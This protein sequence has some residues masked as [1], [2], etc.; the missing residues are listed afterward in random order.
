MDDERQFARAPFRLLAIGDCNTEGCAQLPREASLPELI[1][2]LLRERGRTVEVHNWGRTMSTTREGLARVRREP[3][4]A[5]VVLINFG[6]VDAWVTTI[7]R[8]YIP[9]YPD[10]FLRKWGRKL[11]KTLKRRLRQPWLKRFVP[12]GEVVPLDEY[13]DNVERMIASLRTAHPLA[14]IVLWGTVPVLHDQERNR[15]LI[16]YN[17]SLRDLAASHNA[18]YVDA[19]EIVTGIDKSAAYL[20]LVHLNEPALQRIAEAIVASLDSP[21]SNRRAA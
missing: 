7:P 4:A 17:T 2:A 18:L 11:L 9:Y 19:A 13:R 12:T 1:A 15:K 20:D 16:D 6:L 10:S 3:L 14:K 8:I 5:D 21:A